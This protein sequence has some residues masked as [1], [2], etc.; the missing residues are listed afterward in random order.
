ML[1]SSWKLGLCLLSNTRVIL[2]S[3]FIIIFGGFYT[4][5]YDCKYCNRFYKFRKCL[6]INRQPFLL[7]IGS[8][9]FSLVMIAIGYHFCHLVE[10]NEQDSYL[11]CKISCH[12]QY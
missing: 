11:F 1:L 12:K 9:I 7:N 10:H 3:D 4:I 2:E 8:W 6:S 5:V